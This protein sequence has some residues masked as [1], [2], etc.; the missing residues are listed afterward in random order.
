MHQETYL[1]IAKRMVKYDTLVLRMFLKIQS[2]CVSESCNF[3][4]ALSKSWIHADGDS[5]KVYFW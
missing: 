4:G 3:K 1:N 5:H 2:E